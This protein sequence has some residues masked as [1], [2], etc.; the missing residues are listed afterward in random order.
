MANSHI[1][2]LESLFD[3]KLFSQ[4]IHLNEINQQ[5]IKI[6]ISQE[7]IIIFNIKTKKQLNKAKK[8]LILQPQKEKTVLENSGCGAVG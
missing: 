2:V 4:Q 3:N 5:R 6:G 7:K 1:Y 8:L